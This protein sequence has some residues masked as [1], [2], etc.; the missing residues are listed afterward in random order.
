MLAGASAYADIAP[1]A[2]AIEHDAVPLVVSPSQPCGSLLDLP[3]HR[4]LQR[5]ALYLPSIPSRGGRS[6][7]RRRPSTPPTSRRRS[8]TTTPPAS[9]VNLPISG[10]TGVISDVNVRVSITH[11]FDRDLT[12]QLSRRAGRSCHWCTGRARTAT[13]SPIPCS[14]TR[15]LR[16]SSA[17]LR[18]SPEPSSR[19]ARS[20]Y[21]P[22]RRSTV[23]GS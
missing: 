6:P 9:A 1:D 18:R 14:T 8:R 23:S 13:T 12:V 20:P 16:R 3:A 5:R 22:A 10:V 21:W 4:H 17:R 19:R 7:A 11:A 2:T 15:H